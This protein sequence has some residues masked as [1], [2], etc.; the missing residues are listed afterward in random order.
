VGGLA[1]IFGSGS[2]AVMA[3]NSTCELVA[4]NSTYLF[5]VLASGSLVIASGVYDD[6]VG[7]DA[8]RSSS[9]TAAATS[10]QLASTSGRSTAGI[11]FK[12]ASSA[13]GTIVWIFA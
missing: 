12:P 13:A 7:A 5:A 3:A 1:I 2:A 10:G 6:L 11:E 4:K 8:R 9:C